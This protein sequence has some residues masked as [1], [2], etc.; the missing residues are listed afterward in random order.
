MKKDA[1]AEKVPDWPSDKYRVIYADPPWQYNDAQGGG[2]S[3]S[4]RTN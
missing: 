2:I 4:F 1:V 3:A